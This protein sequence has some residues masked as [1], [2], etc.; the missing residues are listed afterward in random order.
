MKIKIRKLDDKTKAIAA[1]LVIVL[2]SIVAFVIVAFNLTRSRDES[3]SSTAYES[4]D[5]SSTRITAAPATAS[6]EAEQ[7][8]TVTKTTTVTTAPPETEPEVTTEPRTTT[9]SKTVTEKDSETET[10]T[11]Q[12]TKA[13]EK[14]TTAE[15]PT[16]TAEQP[17]PKQ[18]ANS[19]QISVV[20]VMQ[21]PELPTG[22]ETTALTTLLNHLGYNVD[23]LTLARDYLP[24]EPFYYEDGQLHGADFRTT[25]AGDPEDENSYGCYAPCIVT[26]ANKY[27]VN[28][29]A[30]V[31]A[32]NTT[33]T[34]LDSL[35]RTYIDKDQPVLI[36][37]TYGDL[38]ESYLTTEWT[39]PSGES[40][41][42]RAW[43]H[44]VVLTGYDLDK[45]LIYVSDPLAGNVAYSYDLLK[46]RFNEMGSQSVCIN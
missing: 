25:F 7:E 15:K 4:T 22:C 13:P 44:C 21:K 16:T 24:K 29:A 23:K 43:E 42:W 31:R 39:T 12:T 11:E 45:G 14:Q 8:K 30:D 3:D 33:G 18:G 20:N 32:Y 2:I 10:E 34:D 27:L 19:K 5:S 28:S 41:R 46:Q 37:I 9:E 38:H 26:T 40:V 6:S 1:I 17:E 36:W 35:L